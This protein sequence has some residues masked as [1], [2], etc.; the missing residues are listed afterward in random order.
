MSTPPPT[1]LAATRPPDA[2]ESAAVFRLGRVLAE[3]VVAAR[4]EMGRI[5]RL[6][7]STGRWALKEIF[8]PD[9]GAADLARIDAAFQEAALDAGVPLPRPV[10]APDGR[11]LAEVGPD[12]H[13]RSVRVY[14]WVDLQGRGAVVPIREVAAIL[15]RLHGLAIPDPRP[16]DPWFRE[17]VPAERWPELIARAG[18]AGVPWAADLE[19]LVPDLLAGTEVAVAGF[20]ASD[21]ADRG[22]ADAPATTMT[23]HLDYNPENVLLDTTGRPVVVDWENSGPEF[24]EQELASAVAEFVADPAETGAFLRAYAD[25][26]GPARIRDR[27][28]F[29][30]I[31]IVQAA[32]VRTYS[33]RALDPS[34]SDEDRARSAHWVADI[35]AQVFTVERI[36]RWLDSAD[37]AGLL[38]SG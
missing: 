27:S 18:A 19:R 20:A 4:G 23:C 9:A 13:R 12:G 15:G 30:M 38:A 2:R 22:R 31:L 17:P 10:V 8:R 36:D 32:L 5:W 24:A 37:R 16:I 14:G 35:A 28:S 25:A 6:E 1:P 29:G 34:F 26:G 21:N 7:T 11:V 33:E 3:P